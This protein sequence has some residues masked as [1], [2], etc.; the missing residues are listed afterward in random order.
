MRGLAFLAALLLAAPATGAP[1][2]LV[3][4]PIPAGDISGILNQVIVNANASISAANSGLPTGCANGLFPQL[5]SGVWS[6]SGTPERLNLGQATDAITLPSAIEGG[7]SKAYLFELIPTGAT[8]DPAAIHWAI[9]N[10]EVGDIYMASGGTPSAPTNA[11][12]GGQYF[13]Q[14]WQFNS[15]S[16]GTWCTYTQVEEGNAGGGGSQVSDTNGRIQLGVNDGS[17]CVGS[18][19]MTGAVVTASRSNGYQ[20][21]RLVTTNA[22]PIY[23]Y[24]VGYATTNV[25]EATDSEKIALSW[26]SN[27]A[28][29]GAIATGAGTLRG[30]NFTGASFAV[31]GTAGVTCSGSPTASFA[32]TNGFV[33]HC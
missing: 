15:V 1:I 16:G 23:A 21:A 27:V 2:P 24:N 28:Q 18:P 6:C 4:G 5:I 10:T 26:S 14:T 12:S 17:S 31:N 29:I 8:V 11:H 7:N 20:G 9:G 25:Q 32:S 33:T 3:Q 19:G 30:V 22:V 13:R